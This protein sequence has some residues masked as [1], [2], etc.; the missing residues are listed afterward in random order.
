M[1]HILVSVGEDAQVILALVATTV[2]VLWI[3][4][5]SEKGCTMRPKDV[6]DPT[7]DLVTLGAPDGPQNYC[8][9]TWWTDVLPSNCPGDPD[10]GDVIV[11]S[12][13]SSSGGPEERK[14]GMRSSSGSATKRT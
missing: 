2:I 10:D 9:Q 3:S 5:E 6:G 8:E 11:A 4:D 1:S 12:K 13:L 7:D 14:V